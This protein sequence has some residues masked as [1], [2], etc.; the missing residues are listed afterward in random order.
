MILG[1]HL[2]VGSEKVVMVD[3]EA[4]ALVVAVVA[5]IGQVAP[6]VAGAVLMVVGMVEVNLVVMEDTV[7]VVVW[8]LT[9]KS[10]PT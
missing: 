1:L 10:P 8:G 5:D 9:G 2:V 7:L 4:V 6:M 3:L